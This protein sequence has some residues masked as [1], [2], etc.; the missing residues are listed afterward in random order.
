MPQRE[1]EAR[2]TA[3]RQCTGAPCHSRRREEGGSGRGQQREGKASTQKARRG[4]SKTTRRQQ[5]RQEGRQGQGAGKGRRATQTKASARDRGRREEKRR[6]EKRKS[7]CYETRT[8]SLC[9]SHTKAAWPGFTTDDSCSSKRYARCHTFAGRSLV[10]SAGRG[11]GRERTSTLSRPQAR[12][13]SR[14]PL[15]LSLSLSLFCDKCAV[16][17]GQASVLHTVLRISHSVHGKQ[18]GSRDPV[19]LSPSL[20]HHIPL[21]PSSLSPRTC[22]SSPSRRWR[23]G[24]RCW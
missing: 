23:R 14:A 15:S 16:Q 5:E 9:L 21:P 4:V 8:L 17:C 11:E 19:S 3:R 24:S 18:K 1:E 20:S 12:R 22:K 2:P 7:T 13:A 6:R 10:S